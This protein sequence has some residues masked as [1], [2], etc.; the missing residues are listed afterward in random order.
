MTTSFAKSLMNGWSCLKG[1]SDNSL[2]R[3]SQFEATL[4]Q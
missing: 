2:M 1:K 4:L 3:I